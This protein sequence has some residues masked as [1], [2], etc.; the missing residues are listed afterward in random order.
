MGTFI[1]TS[2][3]VW[4]FVSS[5][6]CS[7]F[8]SAEEKFGV[9][10]FLL[11]VCSGW[12]SK[13]PRN[14]LVWLPVG[15]TFLFPWIWIIVLCFW[16][17]WHHSN[18]CDIW[19]VSVANNFV[20]PQSSA[21]YGYYA[22][23]EVAHFVY[24]FLQKTKPRSFLPLDE[25]W[26]EYMAPNHSKFAA[27]EEDS[28]LAS[29]R[30]LSAL[31]KVGSS[32]LKIEFRRDCRNFLEDSMNCV[33][34][35]VAARSAISQGVKLFVPSDFGWWRR[36]CPFAT[37]WHVAWGIARERVGEGRRDGGLEVGVPVLRAIAEAAGANFN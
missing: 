29:T 1:L 33:L 7:K 14:A 12:F 17:V 3:L 20:H 10:N 19:S 24:C 25:P 9:L 34:S 35:T 26:E 30:V 6:C 37:F 31:E 21:D 36:S 16:W 22:F 2:S 23:G 28:F 27:I 18:V 32:Y 11:R 5:S 8:V 13:I 15:S 4:S